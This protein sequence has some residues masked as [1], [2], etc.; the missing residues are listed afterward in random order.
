MTNSSLRVFFA[1][2]LSPKTKTR[3]IDFQH[4]LSLLGG[5]KIRAENLHITLSFL[6]KI[7]E[8]R[9]DSLLDQF[10]PAPIEPFT[11]MTGPIQFFADGKTLAL[12]L[13]QG[14]QA[15]LELKK[16]VDSQ[17]KKAGHFDL[18]GREYQ[19]HI[20]LLKN[21]E[22]DAESLA[23]FKTAIEVSHFCLMA[24]VPA[25]EGV[26]YEIIEEWPLLSNKSVKQ[27]LTGQ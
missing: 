27:L 9:I 21:F 17:I 6:G 23:P 11:I 8:S 2:D 5:T 4:R 24:S 7:S 16:F 14:I 26:R 13:N 18:D 3:L 12:G 20:S 19:P 1:L 22:T 15:L 10:K 25:R